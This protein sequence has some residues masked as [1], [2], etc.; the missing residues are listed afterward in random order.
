MTEPH[1]LV[2][3]EVRAEMARQRMSQAGLAKL[4]GVAQQTV[5]RRLV[6]EVPFDVAE[7]ARIADLLGVPMTQF[8]RTTETAAT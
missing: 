7:L 2:A 3:A 4:L 8:V 5:S 1:Q 6:G